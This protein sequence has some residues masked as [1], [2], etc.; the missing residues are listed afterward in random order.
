MCRLLGYVAREPRSP[1]NLLGAAYGSFEDF[2]CGLHGD[3]WGVAWCE[4]T[5]L[6][7]AKEVIPAHRSATYRALSER[8]FDAAL[9]HYRWATLSLEVTRANTYPFVSGT[10]AFA[11]NGSIS[12]PSELEV[13]LSPEHRAAL[14]GTTDSER[15]FRM[16][17]S[18]AE[19]TDLAD[20]LVSTGAEIADTMSYTS[21][22]SLML[23]PDELYAV[24]FYSAA[25]VSAH[26]PQDYYKM[27]YGETRDA[28]VV[29]SSG[30]KNDDWLPL[31]NGTLLIINRA[32]DHTSFT[33][34]KMK[35]ASND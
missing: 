34:L 35:E 14:E 4:G 5:A 12:R 7:T 29:A 2:S 13:F 22:N 15:Y 23:T 3:G 18:A 11:H 1:R 24:C 32:T 21:L 10:A 33:S 6:R 17:L 16:V 25:S 28:V 8:P 31:A 19:T 9:V 30:W 27:H 26:L 20:A